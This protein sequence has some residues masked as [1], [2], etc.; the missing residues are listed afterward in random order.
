MANNIDASF[1]I[2]ENNS[3]S[4]AQKIGVLQNNRDRE[5]QRQQR[6][7]EQ[8][9]TNQWRNQGIISDD[10][11]F[12][13]YKTGEQAIDGYAQSELNKIQ[14]EALTNHIN[15]DPAQLEYWL[16][17]Q[18]V[19]L[20]QWHNQAQGTYQKLN[21]TLQDYN[22]T[23]SN[24]D[25]G[26][27]RELALNKFQN[28]FLQVDDNGQVL[29]KNTDEINNV[30]DGID[31]VTDLI[32]NQAPNIAL[33]VSTGGGSALATRLG[34]SGNKLA[35]GSI[36]A[37]SY[38]NK[39]NEM[40]NAN[41]KDE[42]DYSKAQ[43]EL[44]SIL[45]G[46]SEMFE[47]ATLGALGKTKRF[48]GA[49]L[50]EAPTR[51][52]FR[53]SIKEKIIGG[54]KANSKYVLAENVEEQVTNL[55]Q[56]FTEI[57]V[58]DRKE[59]GLFDNAG[60]V[61]KSSTAMALL[62]KAP[63]FAGAIAKKFQPKQY[64]EILDK[65]SAEV[66]SLMNELK[67]EGLT[68]ETKKVID[69]RITK[70][71][72]ES[73]AIVKKTFERIDNLP[74]EQVDKVVEL[75][76]STADLR[77]KAE[78]V[79]K[80]ESLSKEMKENLIKD[81]SSQYKTQEDLR[82]KIVSEK[83]TILDILPEEE[84]VDLKKQ[85]V[86]SLLTE[87][88]GTNEAN[89]TEE[90]IDEKAIELY[91]SSKDVVN[92]EE[93]NNELPPFNNFDIVG[94]Q[95]TRTPENT[96]TTPAENEATP[97]Q[98]IVDN[99]NVQPGT[100][101]V[102][103]NGSTNEGT[104]SDN[105]QPTNNTPATS[106]PKVTT[107]TIVSKTAKG[108]D[109]EFDVDF[110]DNNNIIEVRS[111]K[112]GR[113]IP[114]FVERKTKIID[115][116]N[117]GFKTILAKNANYAK[118]EADYYGAKTDNQIKTEKEKQFNDTVQNFDA[119]NEYEAALVALA[120]GSKISK[121]SLQQETGNS[122]NKW[123]TNQFST[124]ELPSIEKLSEQISEENPNLNQ[125]EIRNALIDI[126]TSNQSVEDVKNEVVSKYDE[127]NK[128]YQEEELNAYL[129]TLSEQE[130]VTYESN[131]VDEEFISELTDQEVIEY[132]Q[133]KLDEYEQGQR[134]TTEQG[135]SAETSI[136]SRQTIID[137]NENQQREEE[138]PAEEITEP[139]SLD[140][141]LNQ[142]EISGALDWLDSLKLDSNDLKAT[143]PFLPQT[144]NAFI[145]AVHECKNAPTVKQEIYLQEIYLQDF[146][147]ALK[148]KQYGFNKEC[149]HY[150]Y[151]QKFITGN[152]GI[153]I[154]AYDVVIGSLSNPNNLDF[155]RLNLPTLQEIELNEG[156]FIAKSKNGLFRIY[157]NDRHVGDSKFILNLYSYET[158][159][160]A[161][162]YAWIY[163][164]TIP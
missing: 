126:I 10:L 119:T 43:I 29:R 143:L 57:N 77:A 47:T 26:K 68:P 135:E 144:W 55:I 52:L 115:K 86:E 35:L 130:L 139:S 56:N 58:L 98:D 23:Y 78:A 24:T 96:N 32:G 90:K 15:D 12:D 80:D 67:K 127:K 131:R 19:P 73:D 74:A 103:Q 114:K 155:S 8:Q 36:G 162:C 128:N 118:I 79:Q 85:A 158:E 27:A 49:S 50:A 20:S 13:K 42:T 41:E 104:E 134:A 102:D 14:K 125:Q 99:G 4:D 45:Y 62:L 110:D 83:A 38:G 145:D 108:A 93:N 111:K 7:Y 11:N 164:K 150:A 60:E 34:V 151:T 44:A 72:T 161:R 59:V 82:T 70:L 121:E 120:S 17:Q 22:K 63:Q 122:D 91:N 106:E 3:L 95:N 107:K 16:T 66:F 61:L 88:Q 81:L 9:K 97:S 25:L 129:N 39:K 159:L 40:T 75:E 153:S 156:V 18:L 1:A 154:K 48:I 132:F 123:A 89:Y 137:S 33:M 124:Q 54:L 141:I 28:D 64:N 133:Q 157:T 94:N 69:D 31:F 84:V 138:Q 140:N 65:N 112:D 6:L 105:I 136:E 37:Y 109:S 71:S 101:I 100:E 142:D 149:V 51:E 148:M 113:I 117:G 30:N 146:E 163:T 46:G 76:K 5:E 92:I 21:Q 160:I 87:N 53:K 147:L 152:S 2:Q 116:I